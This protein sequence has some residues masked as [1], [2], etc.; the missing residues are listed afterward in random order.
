VRVEEAIIASVASVALLVG[1]VLVGA[2]RHG[3]YANPDHGFFVP[4]DVAFE[5]A[6][7]LP[8]NLLACVDGR[9]IDPAPVASGPGYVRSVQGALA[10]AHL[11]V[12]ADADPLAAMLALPAW[13]GLPNDWLGV[14]RHE[15]LGSSTLRVSAPARVQAPEEAPFVLDAWVGPGLESDAAVL[16]ASPVAPLR[17]HCSRRASAT[18]PQLI[19]WSLGTGRTWPVRAVDGQLLVKPTGRGPYRVAMVREGTVIPLGDAV[20]TGGREAHV[21]LPVLS[22]VSVRPPTGHRLVRLAAFDATGGLRASARPHG[23]AEAE[24]AIGIPAERATLLVLLERDG[25]LEVRAHA[26]TRG[27]GHWEVRDT[28]WDLDWRP[29]GGNEAG[30]FALYAIS[31]ERSV[32]RF[33]AV[34]LLAMNCLKAW[35]GSPPAI[36]ANRAELS[37]MGI[38][39]R[40]LHWDHGELLAGL[41]G[42]EPAAGPRVAVEVEGAPPS[43]L[44]VAVDMDGVAAAACTDGTGRARLRCPAGAALTIATQRTLQEVDYGRQRS[45]WL[46]A[47]APPCRITLKAGNRFSQPRRETRLAVGREAN[48]ATEVLLYGDD[49]PSLEKP[50]LRMKAGPRLTAHKLVLRPRAYWAILPGPRAVRRLRLPVRD[51]NP[52]VWIIPRLPRIESVG[53]PAEGTKRSVFLYEPERGA[54]RAS[55]ASAQVAAWLDRGDAVDCDQPV[56]EV[57]HAGD[58]L[59]WRRY[60]GGARPAEVRGAD[61]LVRIHVISETNAL[62]SFAQ[63]RLTHLGSGVSVDFP[64]DHDARFSVHVPAGRYRMRLRAY[65]HADIEGEVDVGA[66]G[67]ERTFT[68]V[69]R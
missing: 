35:R 58:E 33:A 68:M 3:A 41:L 37:S 56:L 61:G 49:A 5:E 69:R 9:S 39:L 54:F 27:E 63:L 14:R 12:L 55:A 16:S 23:T 59:T 53:P 34:G 44:V 48:E 62:L 45:L 6:T 30:R 15:I 25:V 29:P 60:D 38:E 65:A 8:S 2:R 11:D 31:T 43:S 10:G 19:T 51:A 7:E 66:E 40:I 57:V 42:K 64:A 20:P 36:R 22:R 52:L 4:E 24:S 67:V 47:G 21:D 13:I 18:V 32:R 26:W 1:S 50:L 28:T 46:D 17:V